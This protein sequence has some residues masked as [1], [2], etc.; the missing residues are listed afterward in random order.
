MGTLN[1]DERKNKKQ[2]NTHPEGKTER[3]SSSFLWALISFVFINFT[4]S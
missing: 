4:G 1:G 3:L 2:A